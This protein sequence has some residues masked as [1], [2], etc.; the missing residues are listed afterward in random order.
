[1]VLAVAGGELR[2]PVLVWP[3]VKDSAGRCWISVQ[4]H[5]YW[6]RRASANTARY[7]QH[8]SEILDALGKAIAKEAP[9]R[10]RQQV[11]T[12]VSPWRGYVRT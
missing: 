3:L 9:A 7:L 6:L 5:S 10:E 1:M 12:Y 8:S 2:T 4:N 11:R